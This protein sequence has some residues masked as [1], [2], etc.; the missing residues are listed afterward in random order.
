MIDG[1]LV[2]VLS[3]ALIGNRDPQPPIGIH[4]FTINVVDAEWAIENKNAGGNW[5]LDELCWTGRLAVVVLV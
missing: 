3:S 2:A 5:H 4:Q 1:N